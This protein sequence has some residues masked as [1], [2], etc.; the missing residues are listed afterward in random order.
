MLDGSCKSTKEE[1]AQINKLYTTHRNKTILV[2]NKAD[3][4]SISSQDVATADHMISASYVQPHSIEEINNA[5]QSTINRLFA[6]IASPLLLNQRQFN[7]LLQLEQKLIDVFPFLKETVQYELL[8][9]HLG[10]AATHITE[11]T[12]KTISEESMDAVFREFCVGK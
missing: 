2:K 8:S 10:D 6:T 12:G 3:L 4:P 11:L 5:I 1:Q 7:L 9:Y